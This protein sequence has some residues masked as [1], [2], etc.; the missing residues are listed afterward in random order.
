MWQLADRKTNYKLLMDAVDVY[1]KVIVD[2]SYI[3]IKITA[4]IAI[5]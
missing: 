4:L 3:L 5:Y 2:K 1:L